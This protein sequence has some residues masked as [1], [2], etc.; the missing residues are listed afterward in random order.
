MLQKSNKANGLLKERVNFWRNSGRCVTTD[1]F[2]T[3]LSLAEQLL[4]DNIYLVGTMRKNRRDLP[5]ILVDTKDRVQYS[6][7]FLFTD[8]LTLVSYVPKPKKCVVLLSTLHHQHDISTQEDN[9]K[10][11]I[12]K[13]YNSTKSGVDLLDKLIREYSTRRC[14]RR[15]PL[16]LFL[17]YVDIAAYNAIGYMANKIS[18]VGR[19]KISK[20]KKKDIHTRIIKKTDC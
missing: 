18:R 4:E 11:K 17:H 2:F 10:P 7:E 13:Y 16:S 12:I 6:S 9:F 8:N 15:W 14:T 19:Q 3:D 1:N 5:K 20:N